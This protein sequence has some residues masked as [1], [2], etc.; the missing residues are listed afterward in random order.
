MKRLFYPLIIFLLAGCSNGPVKMVTQNE[1][2]SVCRKWV[3]VRSESICSATI[4]GAG[5]GKI[6]IKGQTNLAEAKKDILDLL[7]S[8]GVKCTDSIILYPDASAGDRLRGLITVSVCNIRKDP[9]HAAELITQAIMGT[10]VKVLHN[11]GDWY[12]VQTP[13]LYIGWVD[14]DAVF[15]LTEE[16]FGQWK[17]S[18]RV[19]T[20]EKVTD[21]TGD[22]GGVVTDVV[23]GSIL[24]VKGKNLTSY[25][26]VLPDGREGK[27]NRK[28]A[29]DFRQWASS[30][31]K[32]AD[33]LIK[34]G[35]SLL[36]TQYL[37]GGISCKGIDC[38]GF[39]HACYFSGGMIITRDAD[40]QALYGKNIDITNSY[41]ALEPGDLLFF[42][43][44]KDGKKAITHV[45]M[46][47][48]N[49]EVIHSSGMVKIN[50]LDPS[51]PNY[52]KRLQNI[53]LVAKRFLGQPYGKG[54][55]RVIDHPWYF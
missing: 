2:D 48:G 27:I 1:I 44:T 29:S 5:E 45:G 24:Q 34:F 43:H 33:E 4:S 35:R 25:D 37:W 49:G 32:S 46:Y 7:N 14:D 47:I 20:T 53:L 36:G 21:I 18:E 42:G 26:V 50:S 9:R 39:S 54:F 52:S 30:P 12:L 17:K 38:S 13:D 8:R 19:I 3:P 55:E 15:L 28:C 23:S 31:A 16:K 10:P 40:S 51:K 22:D 6:V 41:A 11:S